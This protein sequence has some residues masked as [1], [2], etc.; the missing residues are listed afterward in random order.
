LSF[1][2]LPENFYF[3]QFLF[4]FFK[5]N[6]FFFFL[7]DLSRVFNFW[8]LFLLLNNGSGKVIEQKVLLLEFLVLLQAL[9]GRK[10]RLF[11]KKV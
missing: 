2:F 3:I 11:N 7:L 9:S 10:E 1:F 6:N 4:I 8:C 5:K